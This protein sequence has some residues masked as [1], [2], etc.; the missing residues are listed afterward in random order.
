MLLLECTATNLPSTCHQPVRRFAS[1]PVTHKLAHVCMLQ[2]CEIIRGEP[3]LIH[4][5]LAVAILPQHSLC[6]PSN[7]TATATCSRIA[8]DN[9]SLLREPSILLLA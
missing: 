1:H 9:L 5:A 2:A 4:F 3:V 7:R 8:G 6:N